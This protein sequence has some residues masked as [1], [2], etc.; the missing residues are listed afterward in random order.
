MFDTSLAH[1]EPDSG[2]HGQGQGGSG[3]IMTRTE[4]LHELPGSAVECYDR[5]LAVTYAALYG[6]QGGIGCKG[7]RR[8]GD[9]EM[10]R[11]AVVGA[12]L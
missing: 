10:S 3:W 12:L 5:R 7:L 9:R 2:S 8:R 11:P 1:F 4:G 6:A